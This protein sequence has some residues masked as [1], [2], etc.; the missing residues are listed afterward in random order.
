PAMAQVWDNTGDKLLNGTYYFREVTLTS[1]DSYAV[2][3]TIDFSNGTYSI[4]AAA[5]QASTGSQGPYTTTGTYSLAASGFGFISNP[6]IGSPIYGLLGANGVFVGSITESNVWDIFV[7][8]PKTSQGAN[9]LSGPYS[10]SYMDPMGTLTGNL[11]F[12]ALLE[13]NSN[14]SGSIGNVNLTAYSDTS[15]A[16]TQS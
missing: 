4:D 5:I 10:L 8:A 6:L 3:G 13:L 15:N 7:A 12:G 1:N 2:Y 16:T 14:G 11:P 9:T